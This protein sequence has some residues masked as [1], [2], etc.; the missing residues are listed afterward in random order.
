MEQ[1]LQALAKKLGQD[2]KNYFK[3]YV[4]EFDG[5]QIPDDEDRR[6]VATLPEHLRNAPG[7]IGW[8]TYRKNGTTDIRHFYSVTRPPN[9]AFTHSAGNGYAKVIVVFI[10]FVMDFDKLNAEQLV[11]GN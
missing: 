7:Y 4:V 1:A 11:L 10:A 9:L 2:A 6:L 8:K 3:P 5:T